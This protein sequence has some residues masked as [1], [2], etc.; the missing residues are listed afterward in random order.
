MSQQHQSPKRFTFQ[1][2]EIKSVGSLTHNCASMRF[3]FQYGEIKST[4]TRTAEQE[5]K[6]LHSSMER[7]KVIK[8]LIAA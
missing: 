7:L 8:Y 6:H 3:T 2:G 1:Y 4:F 5:V